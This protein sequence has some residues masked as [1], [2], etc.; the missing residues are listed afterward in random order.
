MKQKSTLIEL[1]NVWKTYIMGDVALDVLK[2]ISFSIY[3]QEFVAILGPSGSGKSTVMNMVGV[4]DI[5]SKGSI[6]L[7]GRNIA[8]LSESAL[9][10]LRGRKIGF[11]FQQFNL[12][13][14]LT[15]LENVVLPAVFQNVPEQKRLERGKKLLTLVGLRDRMF[16]KPTELSG[17]QQQRVAIARSLINNPNIILADE[18]TGNLDS[19]SGQQVI[20]L[21]VTLHKK[22]H[23]TIIIVTHNHDLTKYC[24]RVIYL[25]DGKVKS[26]EEK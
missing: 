24:Q 19:E 1:N 20:E 13:P 12:I 7:E 8:S 25:H 15:A 6:S 22:E 11:I 17:G 26:I 9:A 5:P 18:P 23:K 4:L 3:A 16:H 21:L 10:Q 14:T 2:G